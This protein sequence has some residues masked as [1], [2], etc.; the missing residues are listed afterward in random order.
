MLILLIIII[1]L[2]HKLINSVFFC[3]DFIF[4]ALIEYMFLNMS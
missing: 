1:I 2:I 3:L 4:I